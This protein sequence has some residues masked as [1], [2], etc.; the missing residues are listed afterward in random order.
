MSDEFLA[1]ISTGAAA[2]GLIGG[3]LRYLIALATAIE[4]TGR[5]AEATSEAVSA[6]LRASEDFHSK[7]AD[8]ISQHSAEVAVLQTKMGVS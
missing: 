2:L 4:R 1:I 5:L 8:K 3:A 7:L 6:H